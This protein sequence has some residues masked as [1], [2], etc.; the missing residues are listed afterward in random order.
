MCDSRPPQDGADSAPD[1]PVA[2]PIV[3]PGSPA[4]AARAIAATKRAMAR[5]AQCGAEGQW[6]GFALVC[7]RPKGHKG[8]HHANGIDYGRAVG[9]AP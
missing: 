7:I 5:E 3:V 8:P 2:G 6:G 4:H 9:E 1:R